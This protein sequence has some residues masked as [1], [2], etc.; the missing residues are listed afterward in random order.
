MHSNDRVGWKSW[1]RPTG[2]QVE[3]QVG[4]Q[5]VSKKKYLSWEKEASE[6]GVVENHPVL[7]VSAGI[8]S[9]LSLPWTAF[10]YQLL[11]AP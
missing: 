11:C 5:N 8:A 2:V 7:L 10:E 6:E 3:E 1:W 4:R 9:V